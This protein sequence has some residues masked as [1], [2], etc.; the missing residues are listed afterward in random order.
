[1]TSCDDSV[2]CVPFKYNVLQNA[3]L[4][5][6]CPQFCNDFETVE[7]VYLAFSLLSGLSCLIVFLTYLVLPRLRH[8][9]HSSIVFIYR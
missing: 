1:M 5:E 9:G 2:P 8:G 6:D 7:H 3:S 4:Y